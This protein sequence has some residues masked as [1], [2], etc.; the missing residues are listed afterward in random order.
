MTG[1]YRSIRWGISTL[2]LTMGVGIGLAQQAAA[3]E[4]AF[5]VTIE[6]LTTEQTLML[7]DGNLFVSW[8]GGAWV[9]SPEGRHLGTVKTP[10][11]PAN[12]AWGDADGRTLYM[13]ARTGLYRIRTEIPGM[14]P[15]MRAS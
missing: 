13:T 5:M 7:P 6:Q 11:L 1:A 8:P 3:D 10:E 2:A 12:F 4:M 15:E 9:I 14:R